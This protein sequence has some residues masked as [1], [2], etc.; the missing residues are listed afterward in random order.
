M[1]NFDNAI[2]GKP[3]EQTPIWLMRQAGRYLPEYKELRTKVSSFMEFC[4][5]PD[6]MIEAT[7]QPLRRFDFD[8]AIIFSDILVI[9]NALGQNV[10]FETGKGPILEP[11]STREDFKKLSESLDISKLGA[12]F[13]AIEGVREKLPKDKA[14]IGFC[15]APWT[16]AS[17]MI[18]GHGTPDQKPA[19]LFAYQFPELFQCIINL[20]SDASIEYLSGQIVA[21]ADTIQ[22]FDSWAGVLPTAEFEKWCF[23]PV[24]R[25]VREVRKRHPEVN[26]TV[27]SRGSGLHLPRYTALKEINCL[28]LDTTIDLDWVSETLQPT[29]CVQGN[30]DPLVLVSGG[31]ILDHSIDRI[32]QKLGSTNMIFNLGHGILPETPISHV[33]RLVK[34]IREFRK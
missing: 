6:L 27:F 16:V 32:L 3:T 8:A 10:S 31:E 4:D 33:E 18:A 28:G 15:G 12:T 22:I 34:R 1:N 23:H 5:S 30:L 29:H 14:L 2:K 11:I 25:I 19:R 13:A 17:Y 20:V 21:G 26:I 24:S 7:L 9:P